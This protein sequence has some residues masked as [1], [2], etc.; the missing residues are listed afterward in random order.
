MRFSVQFYKRGVIIQS[1]EYLDATNAYSTAVRD[2]LKYV[3]ENNMWH[4]MMW[5]EAMKQ[6]EYILPGQSILVAWE[7]PAI[8]KEYVIIIKST[9][10][11]NCLNA[12]V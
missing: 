1:V 7:D 11:G 12:K 5:D 3:K 10:N 9:R 2:K 8:E 6:M 4:I